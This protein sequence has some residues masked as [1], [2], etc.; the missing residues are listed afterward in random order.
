MKMMERKKT[1]LEFYVNFDCSMD[2]GWVME[3]VVDKLSRIIDGLYA[4]A[5]FQTMVSVQQEAQLRMTAV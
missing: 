3:S 5:E 2:Y 4:K 1:A